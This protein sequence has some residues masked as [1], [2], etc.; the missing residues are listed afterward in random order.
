MN[1]ITPLPENEIL[2]YIIRARVMFFFLLVST[3]AILAL[4]GVLALAFNKGLSGEARTAIVGMVGGVV[5]SLTTILMGALNSAGR[6]TMRD[7]KI[8]I[9]PQESNIPQSK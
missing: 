2:G 9:E 1:F 6:V 3:E 5:G 8:A 7:G 4:I